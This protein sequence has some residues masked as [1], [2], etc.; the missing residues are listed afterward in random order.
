MTCNVFY[1]ILGILGGR[2]HVSMHMFYF[3][4]LTSWL[5]SVTSLVSSDELATD[6]SRAEALLER[7][8]VT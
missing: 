4:D 1:V 3:R 7:H 6:V 2:V 5:N 8:Q